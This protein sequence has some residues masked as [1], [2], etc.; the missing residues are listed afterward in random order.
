[1][2]GYRDS[3]HT[4]WQDAGRSRVSNEELNQRRYVASGKLKGD[5]YGNLEELNLGS[6]TVSELASSGVH[7]LVPSTIDYPFKEY[8]PTRTP[9]AAKPDRVYL[10]RENGNLLPVA[11]AEYKA[12][13]NLPSE[14]AILKASEQALHS[15]LA[16]GVPVAVTTNG[17]KYI[18]VDVEASALAGEIKVFSETRDLNPGVLSNL[19][20]GDA[21]VIKD[22]KP[23]AETVWQMIWLAT[24]AEPKE[25]LLTFVEIFVLKFLSDNL[26][27]RVL[28]DSYRFYRLVEDPDRFFDEHGVTAIEYYVGTIRPKIKTLFPDNV[29][30]EDPSLPTLF[31][32]NTLVSKTSVI[33]GFAFLRSSVA[34]LQSFNRTFLEILGAFRDFGP[35]TVI[36][37]EFKL[38]LYET[39]LR[40]S[41]RQERLGQFFTPR[42]VVRP[43]IRMAR[44]RQLRD[45]AIVLDPAAGVGGFVLEPLLFEDALAGNLTFASGKPRRRVKPIGV[46]VDVNLH[47][48]GKANMLI[49]LAE[50]VRDPA[51]T[52]TALNLAMAENFVLMNDNETLGSLEYP[53]VDAADVILTNPPY[54]TKGSSS[55]KEEISHVEGRRNGI[56]LRDYYEGSGLASNRCFCGTSRA[57]SS[58]VVGPL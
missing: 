47:I 48:L 19:L 45:G 51:T 38:R 33:N 39:F 43:M 15:G 22:P 7:A 29:I 9:G 1:M 50:A 14:R 34:S 52:M 16:L 31:G 46:D 8:K 26:P 30:V 5:T 55:Y 37:P 53:P 36:D 6:T 44:L 58:R 41:A 23:L 27:T 35:L 25:C 54:V 17:T 11:V 21:G 32:L 2:I 56:D 40:R 49:H 10:R 24:K 42:N 57:R 3:R 13:G 4:V 28:P 18:Y 20:A 12:P